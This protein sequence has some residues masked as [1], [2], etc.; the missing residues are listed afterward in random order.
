MQNCKPGV[1]LTRY[2]G[3]NNERGDYVIC[4]QLSAKI[5]IDTF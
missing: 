5:M 3:S 2:Q 1:K 4:L